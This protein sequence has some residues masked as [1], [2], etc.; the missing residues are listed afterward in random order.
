MLE[1]WMA[2]ACLDCGLTRSH[3]SKYLSGLILW[4]L[5]KRS[6]SH[7]CFFF[8]FLLSDVIPNIHVSAYMQHKSGA[9]LHLVSRNRIHCSSCVNR[10][11]GAMNKFWPFF[12]FLLFS[13]LHQ[14]LLCVLSSFFTPNMAELLA[15]FL[16][17]SQKQPTNPA[18]SFTTTVLVLQ[19][20]FYTGPLKHT[21][22]TTEWLHDLP[23]NQKHLCKTTRFWAGCTVLPL[24]LYFSPPWIKI[25]SQKIKW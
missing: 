22:Y 6:A 14:T 25:S 7:R 2:R 20:V 18:L 19:L 23:Y 5:T 16:A 12:D 8:F 24:N 4:G 21:P 10:L 17:G 11:C 3:G 15:R 9:F 13:P 1:V